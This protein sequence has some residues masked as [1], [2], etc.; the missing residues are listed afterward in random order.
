M[1]NLLRGAG[2]DDIAAGVAGAG[3]EVDILISNSPALAFCGA[4][5]LV[6]NISNQ[7]QMKPA[8]PTVDNARNVEY[9]ILNQ[10]NECYK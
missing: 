5:H 8:E 6:E 2:G 3:T 10:Q 7:M 4:Y 1:G 9:I